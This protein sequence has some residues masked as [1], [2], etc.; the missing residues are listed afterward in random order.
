MRDLGVFF[1]FFLFFWGGGG[2]ENDVIKRHGFQKRKILI[3]AKIRD[4]FFPKK[5]QPP[6]RDTTLPEKKKKK[7]KKKKKISFFWPNHIFSLLF[8]LKI[9]N[10]IKIKRK[11]YTPPPPPP[12]LARRFG[13]C[14]PLTLMGAPTTA[15][16][17][18]SISTLLITIFSGPFRRLMSRR[19][20]GGPSR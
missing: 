1:L 19:L 13:T 12:P 17:F 2:N 20:V 5:G 10:K 4:R 3:K 6:A 11:G 7:K 15:L 9:K 18:S 16:A 14:S 8:F